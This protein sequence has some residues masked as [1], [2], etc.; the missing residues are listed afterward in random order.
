MNS[1][2]TPSSNSVKLYLLSDLEPIH[3]LMPVNNSK[4]VNSKFEGV[5]LG[6]T[7]SEVD[8]YERKQSFRGGMDSRTSSQRS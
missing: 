2:I 1:A 8:T 6:K 5:Q 4:S 3:E 7:K